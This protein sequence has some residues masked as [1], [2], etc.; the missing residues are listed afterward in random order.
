MSEDGEICILEG[1]DAKRFLEYDASPRTEE[2]SK[3]LARADKVFKKYM[4]HLFHD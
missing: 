3:S 4:G 2:E 1:E